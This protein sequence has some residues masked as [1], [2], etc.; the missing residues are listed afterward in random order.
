MAEHFEAKKHAYRQTQDGVVISF[1]CHPNDVAKML[2]LAP[3]GTRYMVA[4]EEIGDDEKPPVID[5]RP[6]A[7]KP[8]EKARRKFE[9]LPLSQ[10]CAI[11]CDDKAFA[12]WVCALGRDAHNPENPEVVAEV[13]RSYLGV[14]SRSELDTDKAAAGNWLSLFASYQRQVTDQR[15]AH[16]MRK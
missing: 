6:S 1:V 11:M 13:T 3:L 7:E 4:V 14:K 15:Y 9:A 16:V 12:K 2:T 8:I 10:Q 5:T